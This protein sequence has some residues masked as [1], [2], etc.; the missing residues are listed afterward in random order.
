[1]EITVGW[2]IVNVVLM[3]MGIDRPFILSD[4][5]IV[6]SIFLL[7]M[8][9]SV[10]L[11]YIYDCC[12]YGGQ[13]VLITLTWWLSVLFYLIS[14]ELFSVLLFYPTIVI[15]GIDYLPVIYYG[16][17]ISVEFRYYLLT[18]IV[19]YG[20]C[21]CC[22][23]FCDGGWYLLHFILLITW[24]WLLE[25]LILRWIHYSPI[26][27]VHYHWVLMT[28]YRWRFPRWDEEFR[29]FTDAVDFILHCG[30]MICWYYHSVCIIWSLW[31]LLLYGDVFLY[32]YDARFD[33]FVPSLMQ[34]TVFVDILIGISSS[35]PLKSFIIHLIRWLRLFLI[36]DWWYY[37]LIY[38][39]PCW[40]PDYSDPWY[41]IL[42]H[43]IEFVTVTVFYFDCCWPFV[44]ILWFIWIMPITST[45]IRE[46]LSLRI[47]PTLHD[48][49]CWKALLFLLPD[50][51][52]HYLTLLLRWFCCSDGWY[53]EFCYTSDLSVFWLLSEF[54][55]HYVWLGD[56]LLM[57]MGGVDYIGG[58]RSSWWCL[59]VCSTTYYYLLLEE[60]LIV[61]WLLYSEFS[62]EAF[63]SFIV[64]HSVVDG[65]GAGNCWSLGITT[66]R[67]MVFTLW[68]LPRV[69]G[70]LWYSILCGDYSSLWYLLIVVEYT[71]FIRHLMNTLP[72]Y[73]TGTCIW[74]RTTFGGIVQLL[75]TTFLTFL[76]WLFLLC[77]IYLQLQ[78][79][80]CSS[81]Q[82]IL[83]GIDT[84]STTIVPS[85]LN[86]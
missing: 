79:G 62:T 5:I 3:G 56:A 70:I 23:L 83:F 34:C 49:D 41:Y 58:V 21:Y 53:D 78:A 27:F 72:R 39:W 9:Y 67:V 82:Y 1:M 31:Y 64:K 57:I 43:Y 26:R 73:R 6:P 66:L 80:I 30:V 40:W 68:I 19:H 84:G 81:S 16:D 13:E 75:L 42:V 85:N 8:L 18:L 7:V 65:I 86:P 22:S 2:S 60:Y 51:T 59:F 48:D 69:G 74:Y 46:N 10:L 25:L 36:P 24:W 50:P 44:V 32:W 33:V 29:W 4:V 17:T 12:Y 63:I 47:R 38:D 20:A 35:I 52:L 45:I 77:C 28:H 11:L 54:V 14:V 15:G 71:L 55:P 61:L 76:Y 37:Y